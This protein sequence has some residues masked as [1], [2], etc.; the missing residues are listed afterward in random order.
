M[1]TKDASLKKSSKKEAEVEGHKGHK[2]EASNIKKSSKK[3]AEV[4]GHKSSKRDASLKRSSKKEA[5]VA[6]HVHL[7]GTSKRSNDPERRVH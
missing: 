6:G 4:E 5:D 2:K 3:E 1:G 7:K